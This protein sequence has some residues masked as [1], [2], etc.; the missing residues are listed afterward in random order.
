MDLSNYQKWLM[1]SI[2]FWLSLIE[3]CI[4]EPDENTKSLVNTILDSLF[5]SSLVTPLYL[6][7]VEEKEHRPDSCDGSEEIGELCQIL[8]NFIRENKNRLLNDRLLGLFSENGILK[9]VFHEAVQCFWLKLLKE[10]FDVIIDVDR[11]Q[12]RY[13][14]TSTKTKRQK[15]STTQTV[16]W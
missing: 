6:A 3:E 7:F 10:L 12:D 4:D 5:E 2:K 15:L 11:Y 14:Q 13:R 1:E 16:V 8:L 9:Y